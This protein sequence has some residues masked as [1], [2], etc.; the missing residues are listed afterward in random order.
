MV[1]I[2]PL[3]ESFFHFSYHYFPNC[4]TSLNYSKF[5]AMPCQEIFSRE[6]GFVLIIRLTSVD[7][8]HNRDVLR[9]EILKLKLKTCLIICLGF[10]GCGKN[11]TRAAL[12]NETDA[13]H[14]GT[15]VEPNP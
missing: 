4:L 2:A 10:D 8:I 5:A 14:S 7:I 3:L 1:M 12:R 13:D 6:I 11:A 9:N 15:A